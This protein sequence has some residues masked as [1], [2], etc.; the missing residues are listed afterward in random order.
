MIK[1]IRF[2]VV[3][4]MFCVALPMVAQRKKK[5]TYELGLN[6]VINLGETKA[7]F[8]TG[9]FYFQMSRMIKK[10]PL[11][12]DFTLAFNS[13][14]VE[15][16]TNI[17]VFTDEGSQE[18]I[19]EYDT[20]TGAISLIPSLNYHFFRNKKI[21]AYAGI[22]LGASFN[23]I[24]RDFLND[25]L[26]T[27]ATTMPRIGMLLFNHLNISFEYYAYYKRYNRASLSV[28]YVF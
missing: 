1:A 20:E 11:S 12:I 27:Y 7:D 17:M 15:R 13:F 18:A 22:G 19:V 10:T 6:Q 2:C 5:M 14:N 21:D 3:V 25:E 16:K 26:R 28:G 8:G 24:E 9:S 4:L 23:A